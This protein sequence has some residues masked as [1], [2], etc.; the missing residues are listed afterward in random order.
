MLLDMLVLDGKIEKLPTF[1]AA[2][3]D[4]A[5][6][7]E[8]DHG[9]SPRSRSKR[10]KNASSKPK[11]REALDQ[12]SDE[13]DKR[14]KRRHHTVSRPSSRRNW[15]RR[16]S[17]H[18][19]DE[20]TDTDEDEDDDSVENGK[21]RRKRSRRQES[22]SESDD[23]YVRKR[24]KC[25]G[26]RRAVRTTRPRTERRWRKA[27]P[28][29]NSISRGIRGTHSRARSRSGAL[30]SVPGLRILPIGRA[31][32]SPRVHMLRGLARR[33]SRCALDA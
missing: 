9:D 28:G 3:L 29:W 17:R 21:P 30:C 11:H 31:G 18:S 14:K 1:N 20:D 7:G 33:R 13:G 22:S 4:D 16:R 6:D 32:Q 19:D 25:K 23:K 15:K 27:L 2:V 5:E 24:S 10:S 8:E 12:Y 26:K